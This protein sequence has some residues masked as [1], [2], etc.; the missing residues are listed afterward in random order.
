MKNCKA[1]INLNAYYFIWKQLKGSRLVKLT[2]DRQGFS[3]VFRVLEAIPIVAYTALLKHIRI[4]N[5]EEL[6]KEEEAFQYRQ[7]EQFRK[8][9]KLEKWKRGFGFKVK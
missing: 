3:G 2:E 8:G 6:Y 4:S 1:S 7:T 9:I 5:Y